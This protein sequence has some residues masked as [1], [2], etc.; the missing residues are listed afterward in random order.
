MTVIHWEI[1]NK[2]LF[3]KKYDRNLPLSPLRTTVP[4][5]TTG[6]TGKQSFY[7]VAMLPADCSRGKKLKYSQFFFNLLLWKKYFKIFFCWKYDLYTLQTFFP[8]HWNLPAYI[9]TYCLQEEKCVH[10]WTEICRHLY[11][12]PGQN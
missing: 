3:P 1:S 6:V 10:I 2:L 12:S 4:Q 5:W 9:F 11:C 7:N 8:L